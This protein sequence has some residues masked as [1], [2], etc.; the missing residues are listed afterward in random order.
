MIAV[1][2]LT[3]KHIP[4]VDR[5]PDALTCWLKL[6][7]GQDTRYLP[8]T[9]PLDAPDLVLHF[10][11]QAERLWQVAAVKNYAYEALPVDYRLTVLEERVA[12]LETAVK[13]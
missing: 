2:V 1:S 8:T 10:Q 7:D 11:A 9:A 12:A 6:T 13:P 5:L 3:E 4:T